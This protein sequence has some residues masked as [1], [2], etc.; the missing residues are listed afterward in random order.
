[1]LISGETYMVQHPIGNQP[2]ALRQVKHNSDWSIDVRP[3]CGNEFFEIETPA[4]LSFL[5]DA[6]FVVAYPTK[7]EGVFRLLPC[8]GSS[9]QAC[10]VRWLKRPGLRRIK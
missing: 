2:L 5:P 3:V 8:E 7:R 6:S 10:T 4:D 1:M 9:A